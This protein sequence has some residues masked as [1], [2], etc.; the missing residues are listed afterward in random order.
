MREL[1][2]L[3]HYLTTEPP[4][5][6]NDLTVDDEGCADC[7]DLVCTC[8]ERC[9]GCGR[10]LV[11]CASKADADEFGACSECRQDWAEAA[12]DAW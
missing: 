7:G 8:D 3:D 11:L 9:P 6:Q 4:E 1:R 5:R 10:M 12:E 2:G